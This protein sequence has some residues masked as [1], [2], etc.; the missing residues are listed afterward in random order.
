MQSQ[1]LTIRSNVMGFWRT[2][3]YYADF[4]GE[5][6]EIS[7]IGRGQKQIRSPGQVSI[8]SLASY[9]TNHRLILALPPDYILC[10]T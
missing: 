7:W 1:L 2:S 8:L 6:A 5:L 10:T 3:L 9:R 4:V